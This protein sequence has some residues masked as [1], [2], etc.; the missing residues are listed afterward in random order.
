M[1]VHLRTFLTCF[2]LAFAIPLGLAS[3]GSSAAAGQ[4]NDELSVGDAAPPWQ[5]LPDVVTG[6]KHSLADLKDSKFVVV[7]FTCNSCPVALEYEPRI[8]DL[9]KKY[10]AERAAPGAPKEAKNA[11]P[12]QIAWVAINVNRV[13]EDL[14]PAMKK[15]AIDK[16]YPFPYL[17]DES[18]Q[19]AKKFG[20]SFTPEFYLLSPERKILYMGALDDASDP[21]QVKHQ[22]LADAIDAAL[23]GKP[24][25]VVETVPRGC[26]I[27]YVRQR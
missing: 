12:P 13:K 22:Y 24:P 11:A 16:G 21:K 5:D 3:A 17:Y 27:R 9:A 4:F 6:Q 10:S 8:L 2:A 25:A 14:P 15:R 20:A 18:Q 19:I 7:V 26:R 23:A 1:L